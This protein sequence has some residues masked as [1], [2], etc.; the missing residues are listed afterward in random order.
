MKGIPSLRAA[1]L[2]L[3]FMAS[4]LLLAGEDTPPQASIAEMQ[5]K[6]SDGTKRS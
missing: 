5:K 3:I 1:L 4:A 2:C 6:L